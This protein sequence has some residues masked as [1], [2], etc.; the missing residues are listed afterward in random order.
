[1]LMRVGC[2][3]VGIY[4]HFVVV[5]VVVVVDDGGREGGKL[6]P[7]VTHNHLRLWTSRWGC[8][9]ARG[10]WAMRLTRRGNVAVSIPKTLG[11]IVGWCVLVRW[12]PPAT[13]LSPRCR[14]SL[15]LDRRSGRTLGAAYRILLL[16][17]PSYRRTIT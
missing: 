11:S 12:P 2:W 4:I 3:A 9:R 7:T 17:V 5:V 8:L 14:Y 15:W 13:Q 10:A 1:M 16:I 6:S